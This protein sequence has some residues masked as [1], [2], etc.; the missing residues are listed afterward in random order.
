MLAVLVH[1][2]VTFGRWFRID[3]MIIYCQWYGFAFIRCLSYCHALALAV[4][5]L[6]IEIVVL[7]S[8]EAGPLF[9][10][11]TCDAMAVLE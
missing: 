9:D 11:A 7:V 5:E 8:L 4:E 1:G 2:F 3:D 6:V 10:P